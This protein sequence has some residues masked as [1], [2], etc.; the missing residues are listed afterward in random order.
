MKLLLYL[1]GRISLDYST[2]ISNNFRAGLGPVAGFTVDAGRIKFV[3]EISDS[4]YINDRGTLRKD[5]GIS[6]ITS[7]NTSVKLRYS[8]F[9]Y[10]EESS[11][12][13][14]LYLFP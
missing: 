2:E 13:F 1:L 11:L 14:N 8:K 4:G 6:Y 5:L 7:Q 10:K 3:S 12:L 9:P